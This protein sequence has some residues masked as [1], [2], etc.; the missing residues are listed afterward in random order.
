MQ[1]LA[2]FRETIRYVRASPGISACVAVVLGL[3]FFESPVFQLVVVFAEEVFVVDEWVFGVLSAALGIGAIVATPFL[4]GWGGEFRR[5]TLVVGA[6]V[7]CGTSMVLFALAPNAYI[8]FVGLLGVGAGYLAIASS[9]NTTIQ[10]QVVERMRGKVLAFYVLAI[11]LSAPIGSLLQGFV[12]EVVGP[13]PTVAASGVCFVLTLVALRARGSLG[14]LD[15]EV[16]QPL[17]EP[18]PA[19]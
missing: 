15:D 3:G 9:L 13:R 12:A 16:P 8:G 11:T 14:H 10:L 6:I 17:L 5:Q 18:D 7:L 2:D 19:Q 1:I 4:A